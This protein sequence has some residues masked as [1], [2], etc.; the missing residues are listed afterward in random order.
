MFKVKNIKNKLNLIIKK[1]ILTLFITQMSLDVLNNISKIK[2]VPRYIK[3]F[4]K[5]FIKHVGKLIDG[6][7]LLMY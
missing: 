7:N 6:N 4:W 3:Y 1:V 5:T 2:Y